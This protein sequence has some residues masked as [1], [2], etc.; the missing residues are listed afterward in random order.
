MIALT[1]IFSAIKSHIMVKHSYPILTITFGRRAY[2]DGQNSAQQ[3]KLK[4]NIYKEV[5]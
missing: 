4:N 5:E 2:M 3:N 1:H